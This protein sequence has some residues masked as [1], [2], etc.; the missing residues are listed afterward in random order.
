MQ[1][2]SVVGVLPRAELQIVAGKRLA[3]MHTRPRQRAVERNVIT[4]AGIIS[5]CRS[6]CPTLQCIRRVQSMPVMVHSPCHRFRIRLEPE[7][8]IEIIQLSQLIRLHYNLHCNRRTALNILQVK[9]VCFF[10]FETIRYTI[11]WRSWRYKLENLEYK[12]LCCVPFAV[13]SVS[14]F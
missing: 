7:L 8:D 3:K 11:T 1:Q 13:R 6:P 14:Y 2:L 4:D 12:Y 9:K 10:Y 5:S